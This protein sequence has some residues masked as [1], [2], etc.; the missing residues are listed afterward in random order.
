[1]QALTEILS[2][3]CAAWVGVLWFVECMTFWAIFFQ[4]SDPKPYDFLHFGASFFVARK[5]RAV[6]RVG[7]EVW[8]VKFKCGVRRAQCEV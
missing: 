1:M 2:M 4:T 7:R 6:G 8:S 5:F 3:P